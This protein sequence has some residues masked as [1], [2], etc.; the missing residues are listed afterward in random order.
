MKYVDLGCTKQRVSELCLGVMLM[1][2]AIDKNVSFE[3][4]DHFIDAGGNF[5]D[6]A[7]CYAWWIGKGEF[8]GGE[9]ENVLGQWMKERGNRNKIFLATKVG[10]RLKD[11]YHIRDSK[12]EP[13]WDRVRA[14]YEGL[15]RKVII[16]EVE[17]SLKRLQTD[18]IDLYYTHVYD[19]HT[20]IE[21][22]M[23]VLNI[24]VKE[25]KVRYL[26]ASNLTTRQLNQANQICMDKGLQPYAVLQQEYSYLHPVPGMDAGIISH[27]DKDMFDYTQESGMAFCAYSPLLKGIYANREKRRQYYNWHLFDSDEAVRKLDLVEDLSRWLGI[28]GN[29]LVL[30]WMLRHKPQIIPIIGFSK[31]EQYLDNMA[32]CN[33]DLSEEIMRVMGD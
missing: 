8:I 11:P 10:A 17:D 27:A 33:T 28:T 24:L 25:G 16:R 14:E 31:K 20:P 3:I 15:S 6:T 2:T 23:E 32:A 9:S 19:N 13:E 18:Y 4:L 22:T 21:E 12:G 5:I 7:N 1:G 29:Q 26:G 30:A